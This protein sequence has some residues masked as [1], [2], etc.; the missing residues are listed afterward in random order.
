MTEVQRMGVDFILYLQSMQDSIGPILDLFGNLFKAELFIIFLVPLLLWNTRAKLIAPVYALMMI[1][2]MLGDALKVLLAEPRPWWLTAE[3]LPLDPVTSVYSSPG[4]YASILTVFFGYL[5][6]NLRKKWLLVVGP[7]MIV[8]HS[9]GKMYHAAMLPDHML[10]GLLQGALI[11]VAYWHLRERIALWFEQSSML[12]W[13]LSVVGFAALMH[14]FMW[15]CFVIHDTYQI[16]LQYIEYKMLPHLRFAS[17]GLTI[18]AGLFIGSL[19]GYKRFYQSD[20]FKISELR[21]PKRIVPIIAGYAVMFFLMV[22]ARNTLRD[23][24]DSYFVTWMISIGL[25]GLSAYWL[26]YGL[27][28]WYRRFV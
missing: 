20:L 23:A 24:T 16:P 17:G 15:L 18:G 11:L 27:N 4:G 26:F 3:L 6:L 5:Y 14:A 13:S 12:Q 2:M 10:L 19:I 25:A 9:L 7:L 8:L 1:D 28:A 22:P 21:I